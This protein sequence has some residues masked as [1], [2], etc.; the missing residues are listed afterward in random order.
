MNEKVSRWIRF[1][2]IIPFSI[3]MAVKGMD[4]VIETEWERGVELTFLQKMLI[5]L[6][7]YLMAT[8]VCQ[9]IHITGRLL[10]GWLVGYRLGRLQIFN[11]E[12]FQ[13]GQIRFKWHRGLNLHC[14]CNMI[15]SG[16]ETNKYAVIFH[17]LGGVIFS[18][19]V[20][21]VLLIVS[22][23]FV[24]MRFFSTATYF[25]SMVCLLFGIT[26]IIPMEMKNGK[27]IGCCVLDIMHHPKAAR[28]SL[29][30]QKIFESYMKGVR[31]KDM[32][33]DWFEIPSNL[34][35]ENFYLLHIG[36]MTCYRMMDEQQFEQADHLIARLLQA[37]CLPASHRRALT[38]NRIF[39]EL[40]G[41]NRSE[42]VAALMTP[43]MEKQ[44]K[45]AVQFD[46]DALKVLHAYALL[47]ERDP[48]A[49]GEFK[50]ALEKRAQTYYSA[51]AVQENLEQMAYAADIAVKRGILS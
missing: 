1:L 15:P 24:A 34:E 19:F 10:S 40:I 39:C 11:L 44:L 17:L 31:I 4:F 2:L 16:E 9:L 42:V 47:H 33:A 38:G 41:E 3:L 8:V 45:K 6:G 51:S 29:I 28:A 14:S 43:K 25:I 36:T 49:A 21:G 35:M 7:F 46:S 48:L 12:W 20:S 22:S 50:A 27:N 18:G 26:D 23:E 32:P 30:A 5:I 37:K 13:S